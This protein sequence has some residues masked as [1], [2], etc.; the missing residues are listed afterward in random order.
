MLNVSISVG[1]INST[2]QAQ[3][4]RIED[5]ETLIRSIGAKHHMK[6]YDHS[7]LER[8]KVSEFVSRLGELQRRQNAETEQLQVRCR[9]YADD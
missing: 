2:T 4:R 1:H 6:G 7:P 9:L 5:R 3:S 8:E